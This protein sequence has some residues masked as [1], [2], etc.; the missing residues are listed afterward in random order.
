MNETTKIPGKAAACALV[1]LAGAITLVPL[2]AYSQEAAGDL[3]AAIRESGNPCAHVIEAKQT[4]N[5][6]YQVR[7]N[8]GTFNV[9]INA[10]GSAQV[11]SAE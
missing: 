5:N 2:A 8:S 1:A 7:C 11:T 9:T 3:G 10:D 6:S 4:G